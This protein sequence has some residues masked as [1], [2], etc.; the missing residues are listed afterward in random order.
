MPWA[1]KTNVQVLKFPTVSIYHQFYW[2]AGLFRVYVRPASLNIP[3]HSLTKSISQNIKQWKS[4]RAEI[5]GAG[6]EAITEGLDKVQ[7]CWPHN[8][9]TQ[10]S[11]AEGTM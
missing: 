4:L 2:N 10:F 8:R 1:K 9:Q 11:E 5:G 7:I 3:D 6:R